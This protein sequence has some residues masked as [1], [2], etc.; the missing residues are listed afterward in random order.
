MLK[1]ESSIE[2]STPSREPV[3]PENGTPT[4][5]HHSDKLGITCAVG[6][7]IQCGGIPLFNA[8]L[9]SLGKFTDIAHSEPLRWSLTAAAGI[10]AF[11]LGRAGVIEG[12]RGH[13]VVAVGG[14]TA[15]LAGNIVHTDGHSDHHHGGAHESSQHLNG[16]DSLPAPMAQNWGSIEGGHSLPALSLENLGGHSIDD[17]PLLARTQIAQ[18]LHEQGNHAQCLHVHD[19]SGVSS[20][21][22]SHPSLGVNGG[23]KSHDHCQSESHGW[24]GEILCLAG[25]LALGIAH[26]RRMFGGKGH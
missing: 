2:Q 24:A 8:V 22:E 12:N 1:T 23:P 21:K 13:I 4:S 25:G 9:P 3:S 18:R 7:A 11:A 15:I 5:K 20:T 19:Y 17:L 10:G 14:M 16:A 26:L 6:C